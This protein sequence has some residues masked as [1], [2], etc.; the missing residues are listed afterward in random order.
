VLRSDATLRRRFLDAAAAPLPAA[1]TLRQP[2]LAATLR[3]LARA[4]ARDFYDGE[5]A[6]ALGRAVR[7]A[8]GLLRADDLRAYAPHWVA[9][10][11]TRHAGLDVLTTP[12]NSQGVTALLML[13][14]LAA[15]HAEPH[16]GADYVHAF[17]AAKRA[18]FAV[19]DR[20]VTDPDHMAVSADELLR[21]DRLREPA[22]PVTAPPVGGDTV[23]LCTADADG[24]AC[25]LIQSI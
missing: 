11:A 7:D 4:G 21:E 25:S 14:H 9:P 16:A 2:E 1:A 13:D 15:R 18:A 6:D 17:T 19:R 12:P 23:Y 8:G 10:V 20:Y 3:R 5:L 22:A 24:N